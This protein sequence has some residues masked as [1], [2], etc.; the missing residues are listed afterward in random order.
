MSDIFVDQVDRRAVVA[1]ARMGARVA[2]ALPP[3]TRARVDAARAHVERIAS[4]DDEVYGVTTG[5]GALATT[6]ISAPQRKELQH[7]LLR[8]HAAGVGDFVSPEV[9][10]SMMLIRA[11]TLASGYSGVRAELIEALIR[12][13]NAGVIPAVPEYGSLGASGDLA[14][15]AHIGLCLCGEG[16]ALE[17]GHAEPA[18]QALARAGLEPVQ[19]EVKEGL[20]LINGTDGMLAMLVLA[21]AD[22]ECLLA[23]ADVTAA[24]TLEAVLGTDRVFRPELHRIRPHPGQTRVAA[25]LLKL[26]EGSSI[27]A[28]HRASA[29]LVQDAYS[30]RCTPQVHG[31]ARDTLDFAVQ[32]AERELASITDNPVVLEDGRVESGG[33][34]HGEPLAFAL[35]FLAIA[36]AE[37]GAIAERRIDRLVDA[38]RSE[39]LPPFLSPRAGTHSGFMV[40]HYTAVSLADDNRRLAA[41]A[42]VGSLPTSAMQEDHNSMGWSAA[43][44]L[45]RVV[46]NLNAILAIEALAAAQA[47]DLRAPL[48]PAPATAAARAAIRAH[49]EF[50]AHDRFM[51][52]DIQTFAPLLLQGALVNAVDP[53]LKGSGTAGPGS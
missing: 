22:L 45:L 3:E 10:R 47:L 53:F 43:R 5:F 38:H 28:S 41:P 16:W 17:D 8:S 23:S 44:K 48:S 37:V 52:R 40:A 15:L 39:G 29:H 42:S 35:D 21:V 30:L 25:R 13:L 4:G 14:P 36:A 51:A 11:K 27:M 19:L 20:S 12:L 18:A 49:V 26:L 2:P 46:N 7:A 32:I 24:M 34:F 33:N 50:Q 9:V 31:A 6:R 1:V